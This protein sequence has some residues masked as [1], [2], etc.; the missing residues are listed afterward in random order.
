MLSLFL[1]LAA[2]F[3]LSLALTP[4]TRTLS[5]WWGLVDQPDGRRKIH[6]RAVPLVGGPTL[7]V[8]VVLA[9]AAAL[10]FPLPFGSLGSGEDV[11]LL[12]LL[13]GGVAIAAVGMADDRFG[14]RG[15]HKLCGQIVAAAIVIG[16]GVVVRD[17][18]LFGWHLE[19]GLLSIPFTLFL[20]L[21]AI[22]SLN[23][24]DGMDGLLGSVGLILS[25]A[26]AAMAAL[27]GHW[28]AAAVA[29]ALAGALLGFLRY[30]LPPASVFLGDSGSMLVG[31][32]LGTLAIQSSLKA[33]ATIALATPVALLILP[34]F[35]T[36]AAILR[37]K[38]TGRS[39]YTSDRAHLHHCLL[40]SGLSTWGALVLICCFCLLAGFGVLASRAFDND[41]IALLTALTVI[42]ILITTR[43]FGHAELMLVKERLLSLG[44][45]YF[46]RGPENGSRQ[47]AVRLQGTAEW[48]GLWARL[49][50]HAETRRLLHLRLDVNAPALHEGYHARWDRCPQEPEPW[51]RWRVEIPL[52]ANGVVLGRLD[53]AGQQGDEP[54][55][56]QLAA[57]TRIMDEFD[58][59]P[60]PLPAPRYPCAEPSLG[61]T[62]PL[63]LSSEL[64]V[65]P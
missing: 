46:R 52:T 10:L 47:I 2:S 33:P 58:P 37:R 61:P 8:S 50:H 45:S 23:L 25:L 5:G 15:R 64:P 28:S 36:T 51:N 34:I 17:I 48:K 35:D 31:L 42:S 39:L 29:C 62:P 38:L 59:T 7:L 3:V 49:T 44:V 19:L 11:N 30:N 21:G 14:L 60:T 22:N 55:W 56:R 12:G 6:A 41:W 20:L 1:I 40:R 24:I 43:L 18:Q 63:R 27:A 57:V 13:L 54:V 4:L 9:I 65:H 16:S 32:V 26:L 53:V